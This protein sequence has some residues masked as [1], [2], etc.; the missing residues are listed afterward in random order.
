MSSDFPPQ[1]HRTP[2]VLALHQAIAEGQLSGATEREAPGRW[3]LIL[4]SA[5][6]FWGGSYLARYSGR[7]EALEFDETPA[8][9]INPSAAAAETP[10]QKTLRIGARAYEAVCSACHMADGMGD[11]SKN[12]PPL[13]GS[14]WVTASG[15][16]R[17]IRIVVHGLSGPVKVAGKDWSGNAM[18]AQIKSADYPTGLTDEEVAAAL[19][20]VRNSWGNK[21][22]FV[23]LDHVKEAISATQ[24]RT[25]PWSAAELQEVSLEGG[26]GAGTLTPDQ[27]KA[28]LKALPEDQLKALLQE[29][30]PK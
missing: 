12:I 10:D 9:R 8:P 19:S 1:L 28:Q 6:L 3:L 17:L 29:L 13:A 18:P 21:A 14:E 26:G 24:G 22:S 20:Y 16:Q 11:P 25:T 7:F 4:V 2:D 27:I 5:M 15:P 30:S 23:I